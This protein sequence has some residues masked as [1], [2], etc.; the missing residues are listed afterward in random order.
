ML[1]SIICLL[2]VASAFTAA[3]GDISLP[4]LSLSVTPYF[5]IFYEVDSTAS[6]I[7]IAVR[8]DKPNQYFALG[9]G[10]SMTNSDMWIFEIVNGAVVAS[11][12]WSTKHAP[13]AKDTTL[14]GGRDD[15][16]V[17]GYEVTESFTTVKVTRALKTS[18]KWDTVIDI[19]TTPLIWSTAEGKPTL[20]IHATGPQGTRG[21]T[22][23]RG[24]A[25]ESQ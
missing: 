24:V 4:K 22:Q 7:T 9:F 8:L 20:A 1:K 10:S 14:D 3:V 6:N 16:Y 18:D 15:I 21:V 12:S 23:W 17:L 19:K 25:V 5:H 13:P 2:F 11:D